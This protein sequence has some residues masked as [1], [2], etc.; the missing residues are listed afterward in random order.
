MH[1]VTCS[2][3]F[4]CEIRQLSLRATISECRNAVENFHAKDNKSITL[5]LR[6]LARD[7]ALS[8]KAERTYSTSATTTAVGDGSNTSVISETPSRFR[9][10]HS[11]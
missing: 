1:L 2:L 3:Q 6:T 5:K 8:W 7:F 9:F 10:F 11:A 4:A